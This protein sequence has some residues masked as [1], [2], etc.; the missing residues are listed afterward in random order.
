MTIKLELESWSYAKTD[1]EYP[2]GSLLYFKPLGEESYGVVVFTP[3]GEFHL[4]EI[5]QYGTH[6]KYYDKVQSLQEAFKV[7]ESWT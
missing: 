6:M 7:M 1:N 4:E 5:T 3:K 2:E